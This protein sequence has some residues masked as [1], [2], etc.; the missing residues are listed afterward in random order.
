[1]GVQTAAC[2]DMMKG[3]ILLEEP[4]TPRMMVKAG[5]KG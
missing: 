1:M 2:R 5:K 4:E 3:T